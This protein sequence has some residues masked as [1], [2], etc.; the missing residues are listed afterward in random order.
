MDVRRGKV[1]RFEAG[2][3]DVTVFKGSKATHFV[4]PT[5]KRP[6]YSLV[7]FGV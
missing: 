2:H 5:I 3:G 6:R 4:S 1:K 7:V